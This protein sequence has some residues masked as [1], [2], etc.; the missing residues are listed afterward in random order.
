MNFDKLSR[1]I[2]L[3]VLALSVALP[4]SLPAY[5]AGQSQMNQEAKVD[6]QAG[7]QPAVSNDVVLVTLTEPD[8]AVAGGASANMPAPPPKGSPASSD[9]WSRPYI[10]VS[11][12]YGSGNANT[13]VN[14]LPTAVQFVNLL[15]QTLH[16]NPT[17]I[18]GGGQ[19]GFNWQRRVLVLG[20]ET[21]FSG[22]GMNGTKTVT[23][24]IQNNN[25]PFPGAGFIRTHQDIAWFGTIRGRLGFA[26][27]RFLIYGT[28]GFMY[29]RI[30]N[31][32]VTDFQ[33][34]GTTIYLS[35]PN[36]TKGGWTGG[37]GAEFALGR[38]WSVRGE[39]LHYDLGSVSR[40]ANPQIPL[41]PFQVGYTWQ[42][43]GNLARFGANYRF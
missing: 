12:G 8:P 11:V 36:V 21:D 13:F 10:G 30:N 23:P 31:A 32:A 43:N 16:P 26:V 25:T 18:V 37:G 40:I 9:R 4:I 14:P 39:Y 17:G 19:L 27:S 42:I 15:P 6:Q 1:W 22:S 20:A 7:Q 5:A 24:I 35:A 41:P 29:G 38:G 2:A 33:P 28:G 3:A 34:V